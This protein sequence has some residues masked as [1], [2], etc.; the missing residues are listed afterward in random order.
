MATAG[1]GAIPGLQAGTFARTECRS[2][3]TPSRSA[4]RRI[5]TIA[6]RGNLYNG[7]EA[8]GRFDYNIS[9]KDR[10]FAQFAWNRLPDQVRIPQHQQQQRPGSGFPQSGLIRNPNG[11]ISLI[12]TFSPSVLNEFRADTRET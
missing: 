6:E 11:Q 4:V 12:H 5:R 2:N 7:R 3:S 9:A 1:C 8:S 10:L